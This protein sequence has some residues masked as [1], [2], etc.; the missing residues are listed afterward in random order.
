LDADLVMQNLELTAA[1]AVDGSEKQ[2]MGS[3]HFPLS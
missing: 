2:F 3:Y 1:M